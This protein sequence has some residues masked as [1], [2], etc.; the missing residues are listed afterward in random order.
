MVTLADFDKIGVKVVKVE[1][2]R[3]FRGLLTV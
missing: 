3:G 2:K 1:G